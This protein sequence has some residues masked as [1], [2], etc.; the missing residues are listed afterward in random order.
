MNLR[1]RDAFPALVFLASLVLAAHSAPAATKCTKKD[2]CMVNGSKIYCSYYN[3]GSTQCSCQELQA[4]CAC[5]VVT[6]DIDDPGVN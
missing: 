5:Q 4:D 1:T 3:C 2:F 6:Q